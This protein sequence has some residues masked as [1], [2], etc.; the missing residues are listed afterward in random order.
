[1]KK[2]VL[3]VGILF[4]ITEFA[5]GANCEYKCVEPYGMAGKI[6]SFFSSVSGL[7]FMR[8]KISEGVLKKSIKKSVQAEKLNVDIDSYSSGDLANGIF[9]SLSITGE[10]LNIEGVYL[11][12]LELKSLC[13]FNYIKYDKQGNLSFQEDFP[14]SF[15]IKMTSDDVNKTT[16]S[17]TYKEALNKLNKLEFAGV[18]ITSTEASIRGNKFYYTL[19][20]SLPLFKDQKVEFVAD[21]KVV[22]GKISF[23]NTRLSS[24][25]KSFNLKSIDNLMK[26]ANPLDFSINI[27]DNKN[28]K[29]YIQNVTIKNNVIIS[30]G[31]III[32]KD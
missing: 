31:I 20:I 15:N 14:M 25:S 24:N 2:I 3:L 27:F 23:E 10:N 17:A 13:E 9:K 19:I 26:Y 8:T 7:N 5:F 21:L 12:S 32:P 6:S 29:V 16:Q 22:D 28:A 30:N 18:K 11:S 4:F 1:M